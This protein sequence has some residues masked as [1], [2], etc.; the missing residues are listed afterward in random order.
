MMG[1]FSLEIAVWADISGEQKT[2]VAKQNSLPKFTIHIGE[3]S[4]A[5]VN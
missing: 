3:S 4:T 1:E 2:T 5:N